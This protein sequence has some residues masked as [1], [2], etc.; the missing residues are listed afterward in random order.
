MDELSNYS[1]AFPPSKMAAVKRKTVPKPTLSDL[2]LRLLRHRLSEDLPKQPSGSDLETQQRPSPL[3]KSKALKTRLPAPLAGSPYAHNLLPRSLSVTKLPDRGVRP[4]LARVDMSVQHLRPEFAKAKEALNL[5]VAEP[6]VNLS[7][8]SSFDATD[9]VKS[10]KAQKKRRTLFRTL[11]LIEVKLNKELRDLAQV[12][13]EKPNRELRAYSHA[14]T[15]LIDLTSLFKPLLQ[16]IKLK[17]EVW[18]QRFLSFDHENLQRDLRTAQIALE[19]AVEDRAFYAKQ[20][21]KVAR[22]NVELSRTC[23]EYQSRGD[24]CEERLREIAVGK[25]QGFPPS[26]DAWKLLNLELDSLQVWKEETAKQLTA[27]QSKEKQLTTYLRSLHPTHSSTD[28]SLSAKKGAL[29]S[30]LPSIPPAPSLFS[31][32]SD[33][34]SEDFDPGVVTATQQAS[35]AVVLK[36][37]KLA[38]AT[39]GKRAEFHEEFMSKYA[40]FSESWRKAIDAQQHS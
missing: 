31:S 20:L 24:R 22:E 1:I 13:R 23:L 4:A 17:Y 15:Q 25:R 5:T 32:E 18:I 28:N 3:L 16:R 29:S 27:Q 9:H 30:P 6:A 33:A 37:P 19:R 26:E 12:D 34:Y 35:Q 7:F 14:F 38:I 21:D 11:K 10:P 39:D 40:E 2:P 8:G 36:V